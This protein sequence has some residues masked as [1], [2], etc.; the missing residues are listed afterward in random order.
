MAENNDVCNGTS[1]SESF[2]IGGKHTVMGRISD[3]RKTW[4]KRNILGDNSVAGD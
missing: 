2:I 3:M 1:T 4:N